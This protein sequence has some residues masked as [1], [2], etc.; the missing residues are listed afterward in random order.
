MKLLTLCLLFLGLSL[1]ADEKLKA[2]FGTYCTDCHDEDVQKGDIRLDR[3]DDKFFKDKH[4]LESLITVIQD[5]EMPPKKKKKQPTES[6]RDEFAQYIFSKLPKDIP[7]TLNRLTRDEYIHTVS[8]L[9]GKSFQLENYL[10]EDE[11]TG[12]FK[13]NGKKQFLSSAL[14]DS[15]INA[16]IYVSEK[17]IISKKPTILDKKFVGKEVISD[18]IERFYVDNKAAL[19]TSHNLRSRAHL[20]NFAFHFD[21]TYEITIDAEVTRDEKEHLIGVSIGHPDFTSSHVKMKQLKLKQD[22][23]VI[24]FSLDAFED[25]QLVLTFDSSKIRSAKNNGI[26]PKKYKGPQLLIKSVTVKGPIIKQW[27]PKSTKMIFADSK[28][29]KSFEKAPQI[30]KNLAEKLFRRNVQLDELKSIIALAKENFDETQNLQEAIKVGL[31]GLLCSPDF[32]FKNEKSA[33]LDSFAVA[34]RLAYFLTKSAPDEQLRKLAKNGKILKEDVRKREAHRLLSS[35]KSQRFIDNFTGQWLKTHLVGEMVPDR[36]FFP[37]YRPEMADMMKTETHMFM[38]KILKD[39][40][41]IS[42]IIDSDFTF[43]NQKLASIYNIKN[44]K[45]EHFREV[46]LPSNSPRGGLLTQASVLNMN[47]TG[48]ASSPILRGVW[49]L[50]NIYG[51]HM[52]PPANVK[53]LEPDIRGASTVTDIL[54]KHKSTENCYRCHAKIDPLGLALEKFD[55]V[56]QYRKTYKRMTDPGKFYSVNERKVNPKLKN[57]RPTFKNVPIVDE[58]DYSD[59]RPVKGVIGLKTLL[60]ED[61]G[62]ITKAFIKKLT[63]YAFGRHVS[64]TD[65]VLINDVYKNSSSSNHGMQD[66][67]I[68]LVGHEAFLKR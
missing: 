5:G 7:G 45:G 34:T 43:I 55:P 30:I 36:R 4:L 66:M 65:K 26:P 16:A 68:N 44:V 57:I 13:N 33:K 31:Q 50:E 15:Y 6:E 40:L 19:I 18:G 61:K 9:F 11:I 58:R 52:V 27:P 48:V 46:K 10:P 64:L 29:N 17:V 22:S 12:G 63:E 32:I 38:S 20:K 2:F 24:K 42:N 41:S 53:A 1:Q 21:G 47:S 37:R 54:D 39:N 62:I 14:L 49:I 28:D 59:G 8:D 25:D 35:T 51:L 56:G 23:N 60:M 3:L 67:I